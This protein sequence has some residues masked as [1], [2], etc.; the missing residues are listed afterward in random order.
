MRRGKAIMLVV[1]LF[2]LIFVFKKVWVTAQDNNHS[3]QELVIELKQLLQGA[4]ASDLTIKNNAAALVQEGFNTFYFASPSDETRVNTMVELY[5][6]KYGESPYLE[7]QSE[8]LN[9]LRVSFDKWQQR[10][11]KITAEVEGEIWPKRELVEKNLEEEAAA[12]NKLEK[13][14]VDVGKRVEKQD[15]QVFKLI[16]DQIIQNQGLEAEVK[17]LEEKIE[18]YEVGEVGGTVKLN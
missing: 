2:A 12:F 3:S 8:E 18:D 9:K 7:F 11:E 13:E 1:F 5:Y 16:Q 17:A 4:S 14:C 6:R 10:I 15:P